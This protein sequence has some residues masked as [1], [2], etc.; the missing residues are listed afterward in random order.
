[1]VLSMYDKQRIMQLYFAHSCSHWMSGFL[2]SVGLASGREFTSKAFCSR[3]FDLI[4][5][6]R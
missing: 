5:S 2:S 1:M 3:D 4:V 6:T